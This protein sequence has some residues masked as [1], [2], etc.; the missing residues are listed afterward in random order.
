M[1][2]RAEV[3]LVIGRGER[4]GRNDLVDA[5]EL[6]GRKPDVEGLEVVLE[7]LDRP[8]ADDRAR[9]P[10][11]LLDPGERE[12]RQRHTPR[13]RKRVQLV[14]DGKRRRCPTERQDGNRALVRI[15]RAGGNGSVA[16]VLAAEQAARDWGPGDDGEAERAR[17]R[18]QLAVDAPVEEVVG[19]LLGHE[20]VQ[21]KLLRAPERL[22]D[23]PSAE[24][25][26]A[27]VAH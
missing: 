22:D 15:P 10:W 26:R 17:H 23:L 20:A 3:G 12:L 8:R 6:I 7:L 14:D 21:V 24:R 9:Y 5:S 11:L 18:E 25:R 13:V 27:D 1:R 2:L 4:A 16:P 19:R